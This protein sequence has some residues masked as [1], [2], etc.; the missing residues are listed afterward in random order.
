KF[1]TREAEREL[2]RSESVQIH[3]RDHGTGNTADPS[4]ERDRPSDRGLDAATVSGSA[5]GRSSLPI[6]DPRPGSH[7][8]QRIGQGSDHYGCASIA[9]A[10]MGSQGKLDLRTPRRKSSPRVP[11]LYNSAKRTSSAD[12]G[13]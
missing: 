7:S 10:C 8:F 4:P 1:V 5:S 6:P 11:E 12:D 3:I 13:Q 2:R 9:N